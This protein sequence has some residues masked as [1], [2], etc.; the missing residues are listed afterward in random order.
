LWTRQV[1]AGTLLVLATN[2]GQPV[3]DC[4]IGRH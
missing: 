4:G 1:Q 2:D 3:T